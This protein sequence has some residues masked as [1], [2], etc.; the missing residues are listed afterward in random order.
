MLYPLTTL[1]PKTSRFG[2]MAIIEDN[3]RFD[4]DA[5]AASVVG[6]AADV[7]KHDSGMHEHKKGQLLYA[8]QGCM[9]FALDNS[10][11]TYHQLKLYGFLHI[12]LTEPSLDS[13]RTRLPRV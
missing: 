12:L 13:M 10:I 9:T 4:A 8:P 1:K 3:T 7:G 5:I 11:C 6:I 2:Q